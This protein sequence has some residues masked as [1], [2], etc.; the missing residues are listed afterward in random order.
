MQKSVTAHKLNT[1]LM[2]ETGSKWWLDIQKPY[3]ASFYG[4]GNVHVY[5]PAFVIAVWNL[6]TGKS[7]AFGNI[8]MCGKNCKAL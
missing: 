1:M 3:V 2:N 5:N 8:V 6:S 7:H 4:A